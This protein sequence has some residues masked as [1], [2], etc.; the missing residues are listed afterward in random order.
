[1]VGGCYQARKPLASNGLRE[2]LDVLID[3]QSQIR[4]GQ[5]KSGCWL[6]DVVH[7]DDYDYEL[8]R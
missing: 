1:M 6:F 3:Q 4:A 7:G 5:K 2:R 8:R